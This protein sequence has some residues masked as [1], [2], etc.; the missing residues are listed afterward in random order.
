MSNLCKTIFL[1]ISLLF[2]FISQ[3]G[4]ANG[5]CETIT[6]NYCSDFGTINAKI[7][8][9]AFDS[10]VQDK[11]NEF[12]KVLTSGDAECETQLSSNV[13]YLKTLACAF[14]IKDQGCPGSTSICPDVCTYFS[15]SLDSVS[16]INGQGKSSIH[17]QCTIKSLQS[18]DCLDYYAAELSSCGYE[19]AN[20]KTDFCAQNADSACC[21]S[22]AEANN[23]EASN[24]TI[25]M[26]KP[27]K[28]K[29]ATGE[30]KKKGGSFFKSK[31]FIISSII[32]ALIVAIL[33][34]FYYVGSKDEKEERMR[35][36]EL[37]NRNQGYDNMS[38]DYNR[39]I[40]INKD[41]E[42]DTGFNYSDKDYDFASK[43]NYNNNSN[44]NDPFDDSNQIDPSTKYNSKPY[45]NN[46]STSPYEN[47]YSSSPYDNYNNN[48]NSQHDNNYSTSPYENNFSTSPYDKY[49][50][51]LYNKNYS[52]YDHQFNYKPYPYEKSYND[53][54][55][56]TTYQ[57]QS[58]AAPVDSRKEKENPFDSPK[59]QN[60]EDSIDNQLSGF[61]MT[62]MPATNNKSKKE[63]TKAKASTTKNI[64]SN[65]NINIGDDIL[66]PSMVTLT[67]IQTPQENNYSHGTEEEEPA[68]PKKGV[69]NMIDI[70]TPASNEA[71]TTR[72]LTPSILVTSTNGEVSDISHEVSHNMS[73]DVTEDFS[74][75]P[76]P[77]PFRAIHAYEPQIDDELRLEVDNDID[78]LYEYDDGW[79]WAY[80]KTTDEQGA[81]PLLCLVSAKEEASGEREW[82]KEMDVV[83]VPG[84]RESMISTSFDTSNLSFS[85]TSFQK[86]FQQM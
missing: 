85:N 28:S 47:N 49:S 36:L 54:Q 33:G 80:N 35:N 45:E 6:S 16:C 44:E 29:D 82:E 14:I 86:K 25:P 37:G 34:F 7:S 5:T 9:T 41:K 21:T 58:V 15:N 59:L 62:S 31:F 13:R 2:V 66:K 23:D 19:D 17:S 20:S 42:K 12:K 22:T 52:S 71:N 84:R 77:R 78:V 51:N 30:N 81:C 38:D 53:V 32:L 60:H 43:F 50:S 61:P 4:A 75:M 74:E 11:Y 18:N 65:K 48:N 79:C 83:K 67:E 55:G 57:N 69:V 76:E 27:N 39:T 40:E 72:N 1:V 3:V 63:K 46:Y 68:E 64:P 70:Q 56:S 24:I 10:L 26:N 73:E 8:Q